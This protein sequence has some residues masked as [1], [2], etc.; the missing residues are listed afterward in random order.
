M[1]KKYLWRKFVNQQRTTKIKHYHRCLN[2]T[3]F[4]QSVLILK[5]LIHNQREMLTVLQSSPFTCNKLHLKSCC[6]IQLFYLCGQILPKIP[7]TEFIFSKVA[8]LQTASLLK[9][10]LLHKYF[11]RALITK[12]AQLFSR[13]TCVAASVTETQKTRFNFL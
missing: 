13:N 8:G 4:S 2:H 7:K 3:F 11:S 12:E 1:R 9:N 5:T 6:T 10:K